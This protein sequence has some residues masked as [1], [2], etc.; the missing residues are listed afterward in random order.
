MGDAI[1]YFPS[2]KPLDILFDN[3]HIDCIRGNHDQVALSKI[4][5]PKKD[6]IYRHEAVLK[7]LS[8]IHESQIKNWHDHITIGNI[9]FYH[10]GPSDYQ[11]QYIYPDSDFSTLY[12]DIKKNNKDIQVCV[13]AH[14]HRPFIKEYKDIIFVNSGSV[15]L[16]RDFGTHGSFVIIDTDRSDINIYRFDIE[17]ELKMMIEEYPDTHQSV[18]D[19]LSRRESQIPEGVM[20]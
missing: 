16:P 14:T 5:S 9:E 11:N 19:L 20:L 2:I 12:D 3:L 8:Y 13:S 18:I 7:N 10:G 6:F 17:R 15:G 1:G 4:I